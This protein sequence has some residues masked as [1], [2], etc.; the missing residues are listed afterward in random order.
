[1]GIKI[2]DGAEGDLGGGVIAGPRSKVYYHNVKLGVGTDIVDIR[3]GFSWDLTENLLGYVGFFDNFIVT[4]D[5]P[6]RHVSSFKE[7]NGTEFRRQEMLLKLLA[8]FQG[9]AREHRAIR[10]FSPKLAHLWNIFFRSTGFISF[11]S[12][13]SK[14]CNE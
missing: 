8:M 5:R 10:F 9:Q 4:F 14:D 12:G 3:A 1:M 11:Q 13:S 6:N 7:S 2:H